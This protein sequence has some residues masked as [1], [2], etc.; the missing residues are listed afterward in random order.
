MDLPQPEPDSRLIL[1]HETGRYLRL[2]LREFDWLKRMDGQLLVGD[3]AAAFGQE[4]TLVQ[5][6]LRR[7]AGAKLIC[8]SE[9]PVQVQ[10]VQQT[11]PSR[12][13]TRRVEW[14]QFGQLRIHLGRP[15]ALL[16]RLSP[17]T[18]PLL[19]KPL[20]TAAL[21]FSLF[22]LAL[23]L[24]QSSDFTRAVR[25][26]HWGAWHT[27]VVIAL[28]FGTTI[29][30]ELGHAVTCDY[31]GA[32][33]RSI[34][35]MIYYLQ[36]AAYA[37]VTD[38]WQL[39][40]RWH[41]VAIASAGVYV[42]AIISSLAVI[43]WTVLRLTG[44]RADVIVV[45][46][47][48]NVAIMIFNVLPFVKLDGYW[49]LSN[50]LAIP[51]LRDRA[52]E[53]VRVSMRSA[54]TRRPVE[55]KV[56]RF[57]AVLSMTPLGRSLL[58]CFGVTSMVFGVSMWFGGMGFLFRMTRWFGMRQTTSVLAVAG[59]LALLGASYV[60]ILLLARRRALRRRPVTAERRVP[61]TA[62]VTHMI[63]DQRSI[64]LNPHLSAVD[65][66]D[67][68]IT[69]AWS[70]PDALT[71]Q[72]PA[73]LFDALPTLREGS[74]TLRELR[75][76]DF[77]SPHVEQT[78]QR[79]WHDR[80]LRYSCD[81]EV[82]EENVRYSRQLGWFSMNTAARGKEAEVLDRLRKASVTILGVGG[83]GTHVAWTLAAC[84][85]GEL[86]LVDGDTI[87]LT[88]LN[89]QLFYTPNDIG[90]RKVD[91]TAERLIQFNP[92][93]KVRTTHRYL[94]TLDDFHEVS[95][96][97]TFVVRAVDSPPECIAWVN[98][99][100]IRLGIPY[101]G[102]GFFPQGTIVG[103]T[104]IPW[105]SSCIACNAPAVA[106]RVDRGT[107]GTLAPLVFATAGLLAN[108]V[109]TYLGRLG[110]PQTVNRVLAISAPTLAFNFSDVPRND[111]CSVCGREQRKV[112]A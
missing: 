9:E 2:G 107:G 57:N 76:A 17:I 18:R 106:P 71:V 42:Q 82:A 39:K 7:M 91:V 16:D 45:F 96:G 72:A 81:W 92:Q 98:E 62:V 19:S 99:A 25:D 100:C 4:E 75:Q 44:H 101:S 26:F 74:A 33:V 59:M 13:D 29:L 5:E 105:E 23:A 109:I 80:H 21:C 11:E 111:N 56:L 66:G 73:A 93:L 12:L 77:W 50:I 67:G 85:V 15:K 48:M 87:E 52:M 60:V 3:V 30:H 89:R 31:F 86:H 41:R 46:V 10:P 51:N 47:T 1:N 95:R 14:T 78:I 90:L 28:I 84:G 70:T 43:A 94:Q 35:V 88:N 103:P 102:G 54:V 58:A 79:L 34:G 55:A 104:V 83:L 6:L 22:G 27:L 20:I 112:S 110:T 24:M 40:N 68:T 97:S 49:I 36:P 8:F 108:E 64:R 38:S 65:N 32:P 53:W 63:D 61:V 37:D 69:F